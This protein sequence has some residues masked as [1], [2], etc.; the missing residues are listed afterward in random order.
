M[1][2][3]ERQ[4]QHRA[5]VSPVVRSIFGILGFSCFCMQLT[6]SFMVNELATTTTKTTTCTWYS[7]FG[8]FGFTVYTASLRFSPPAGFPPSAGEPMLSGYSRKAYKRVVFCNTFLHLRESYSEWTRGNKITTAN[9]P[10]VLII[11]AAADCVYI[12]WAGGEECDI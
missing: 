10:G 11:I 5:I 8:K 6:V 1:R 7:T 4:R 9:R 2:Q 3:A 12:I